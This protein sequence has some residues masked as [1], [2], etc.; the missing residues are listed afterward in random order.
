MMSAEFGKP[1]P[2]KTA[3]KWLT[4]LGW[5]LER[6]RTVFGG[7]PRLTKETAR[8]AHRFTHY[9]NDKIRTALG[10][11]FTPIEAAIKH[12]GEYY[13]QFTAPHSAGR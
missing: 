12:A 2:S 4:E 6:L 1:G 9:A 5:R 13:R 7:T 3:G 8:S 11:D 10:C